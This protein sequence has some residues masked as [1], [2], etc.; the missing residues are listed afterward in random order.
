M[1]PLSNAETR[2]VETLIHPYTN[3]D[4]HREAGPMIL[5]RGDGVY[6]WDN[7]GKRYIEGLAG[8]WCTS[9]GYGNA[10]LVETAREQMSRLSFTHLFGG[11]SHDPAIELAE[12]LKALSPAPASKVLYTSSGS[13]ANDTQIKLAWYY[14]N[15]LGR[16]EKKKII[17]RHRAYHGVTVASASLTGLPAVHTDFDLPR[18]G[19]LHTLCPDPYR[20]AEPGET[21]AEFSA[22]LAGALK[23]LIEH[24]GPDTIA[25]FIAEPVMGAGGVVVPPEG[26]FEALRPILEEHDILMI[27]DEV[28]CGFGR[29]GNM[30][31]SQTYNIAPNSVSMAKA[32]TSAYIPLGAVTVS[33]PVYQ[34]MLEE[35]RKIGIF[36]HGYTY[37]GHP[38]AAAVALKTLEIMKRD[39]LVGHVRSVAPGFQKRLQAL[40]EH[41]L[42]GNARGVGLIGGVELVANKA[43]KR[44]FDVKAMV[45]AKAAAL[46][47]EEGLIIRPLAGDIIALC[48]PLII[49]EAE[50]HH[51]FDMLERA[52][53]ATEA[54]IS[55]E[56]LRTS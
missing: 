15:A 7:R 1:A 17:S 35:S 39:N 21:E 27:A 12:K 30:F 42:V 16:P 13:E 3:L 25:A 41:P 46:C 6:V 38:V 37:T 49:T 9:L 50:V 19:V 8:L 47:Q 48:P 33:E 11:K 22:R 53:D 40:A 36:G 55:K 4:S 34:S 43:T 56:G 44:S 51:L 52:L 20:E 45:A 2:D 5:E 23:D 28:I 54:W 18:P 14:N 26:Y 32:L 10:E 31:G 24:E 29:T